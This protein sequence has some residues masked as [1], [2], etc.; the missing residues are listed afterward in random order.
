[1]TTGPPPLPPSIPGLP[2]T[3]GRNLQESL[4]DTQAHLHEEGKSLADDRP[5]LGERILTAFGRLFR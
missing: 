3:R 2:E 5:D 1:M 4:A